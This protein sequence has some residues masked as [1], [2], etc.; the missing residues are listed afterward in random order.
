MPTTETLTWAT[1]G[2]YPHG[3]HP[4]TASPR[5]GCDPCRAC[6]QTPAPG[7]RV[8]FNCYGDLYCD[9]CARRLDAAWRAQRHPFEKPPSGDTYCAHNGC[10][11]T[12]DAEQ[13]SGT[14]AS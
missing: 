4:R 6:R 9:T 1:G 14:L 11:A 13:H 2:P 10:G 8:W 3:Y 5:G 12:R 7:S